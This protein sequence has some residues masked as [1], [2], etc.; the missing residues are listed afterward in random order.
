MKGNKGSIVAIYGILGVLLIAVGFFAFNGHGTIQAAPAPDPSPAPSDI[1]VEPESCPEGQARNNQGQC[2]WVACP[3]GQVRSDKGACVFSD[4]GP[5]ASAASCKPEGH[6]R[7]VYARNKGNVGEIAG[8]ALG[9]YPAV[10]SYQFQVTSQCEAN[11]YF[12]AG[13][14]Q[15]GLL[16]ILQDAGSKCDGNRH[17]AG[18]FIRMSR[19]T[20][21]SANA[22]PGVVDIAFF[23]LD[24]GKAEKLRVVGGVYSGCLRDGGEVVDEFTPSI[25]QYKSANSYSSND[26][27]SS[28]VK[29]V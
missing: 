28:W 10:V 18:K 23:P 29:I 9:A 8:N 14:Q 15:T 17:Y 25:I 13:V 1:R 21:V 7:T 22:Q 2:V 4:S 12:E 11:Y 26:I 27:S 16:T 20:R 24:Y 5:D 6:F 3:T 19:N